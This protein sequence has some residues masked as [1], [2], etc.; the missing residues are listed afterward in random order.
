[1]VHQFRLLFNEK[2]A[3]KTGRATADGTIKSATGTR[4]FVTKNY[5]LDALTLLKMCG[6]GHLATSG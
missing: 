5:V 6:H 1:M 2:S 4:R 3:R